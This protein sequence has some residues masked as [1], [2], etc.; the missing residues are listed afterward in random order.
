M[1]LISEWWAANR[2]LVC[3]AEDVTDKH[4]ELTTRV[5]QAVSK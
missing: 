3:D 2:L 1:P 4:R 5:Q